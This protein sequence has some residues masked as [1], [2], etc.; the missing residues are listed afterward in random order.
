MA[1]VTLDLDGTLIE[2]TVFQAAAEA[3]GL[4]DEVAFYDD[5][6][7]RGILSLEATFFVEYELFLDRPVDEVQAAL[8]HGPWL[9]DIGTTVEALRETGVRVWVVTDQPDWAVEHLTRWGITD[10]VYTTTRRWGEKIG[11]V[12][13]QVFDKWPALRRALAELKLDPSKV[14]HVG[15]GSND[16][17]IFEEVGLAIAFNPDDGHVAEAADHV[18]QD[19]SLA[20][21]LDPIQAWVQDG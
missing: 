18:I 5:L 1:L 20:R 3:L 21:I 4:G 7:F 19:R 15:N 17:P 2:T 9:S 11:P 6:Y 8:E 13:E 12:D 10:G 16:V 14:C